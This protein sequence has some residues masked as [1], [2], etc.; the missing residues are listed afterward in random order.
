MFT[1]SSTFILFVFLFN[2]SNTWFYLLLFAFGFICFS[3]AID[4]N[5]YG[6]WDYMYIKDHVENS[7][8]IIFFWLIDSITC[9]VIKNITPAKEWS[10][11]G[12]FFA[13]KVTVLRSRC[14][15]LLSFE[16]TII[17]YKIN[18]SADTTTVHTQLV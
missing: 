10:K 6:W 17:D 15:P 14:L 8:R 12:G 9:E 3:L 16:R 18:K 5:F 11:N 1:V 2:K 13:Q 7:P 4:G